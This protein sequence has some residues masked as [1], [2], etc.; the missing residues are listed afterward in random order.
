[1]KITKVTVFQLE[2]P[3]RSGL[4]HYV[5]PR[6]H[7]AGTPHQPYRDVFCE[8]ETDEGVT[9]LSYGGTPEVWPVVK[10]LGQKLIGKD[11]N[12]TEQ[13]WDELYT[14]T[15]HRHSR[16]PAMSVLD[17][18][19]WDLKGKAQNKP[20]YQLLGGPTRERVRA[21]AAMAF[22]ST[23]PSDAADKAIAWVEKGFTAL[24][25][26]LSY[27]AEDGYEGLKK[28]VA[29]I[30]TVREAVGEEVD[31]MVDFLFSK[32][33]ESNL[34]Y[35]FKLA[36]A[37]KPYNL[38]WLEEPLN[39]D[40]LDA[41]SALVKATN[42]PIALGEHWNTRWQMRQII[43]AGAASVLQPDPLWAGGITEMQKIFALASTFGL[44]VSPH[45]N[46]S[47]RPNLHLLFAQP[48]RT[49]PIAEWSPKINAHRQYF[50]QDFYAPENGY[51]LPP[52]GAGLGWVL[53]S[54]KV[55]KRISL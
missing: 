17:L 23:E 40:D 6:F 18:A 21:Y 16:V 30:K 51:F 29:L 44:I 31:L 37:L 49:A 50:Y 22:F 9:G 4:A 5:D 36:Q 7:Q 19:L 20:V 14:N 2:G 25:W 52:T 10:V 55:V 15:Y 54:E 48:A 3:P 41:H 24:K 27:G 33:T 8:I 46:E 39:F 53:D 47:C 35:V 42:I 38:T 11:P 1:M 13:I 28:N 26:Y 12:A 34:L 32:P 43:E 45:G